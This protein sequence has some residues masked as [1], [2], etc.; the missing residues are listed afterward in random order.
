MVKQEEKEIAMSSE[1]PSMIKSPIKLNNSYTQ[2]HIKML[3]DV[4]EA[5]IGAVFLDSFIQKKNQEEDKDE[6]DIMKDQSFQEDYYEEEKKVN[7][8]KVNF[9]YLHLAESERVWKELVEKYLIYY[10]DNPINFK[11]IQLFNF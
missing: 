11:A 6:D 8:N 1:D 9:N 3:A 7:D 2:Y 5:L 10:A 4:I